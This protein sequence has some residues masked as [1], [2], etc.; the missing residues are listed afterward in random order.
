[1]DA[2]MESW[3][4]RAT[5]TPAPAMATL[6]NAVTMAIGLGREQVR[7]LHGAARADPGLAGGLM[8]V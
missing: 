4:V 2:C 8:E 6:R 5:T 1:M 7:G 3:L